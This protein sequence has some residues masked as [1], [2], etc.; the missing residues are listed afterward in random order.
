MLNS[1]ICDVGGAGLLQLTIRLNP[2]IWYDRLAKR[3]VFFFFFENGFRQSMSGEWAEQR[4]LSKF[5]VDWE[6][7][8]RAA[9]NNCALTLHRHISV[10]EKVKINEKNNS[11]SDRTPL[12]TH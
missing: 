12:R 11:C 8:T 2:L 6:N 3:D 5:I 1:A 9:C 10:T 7:G 4:K